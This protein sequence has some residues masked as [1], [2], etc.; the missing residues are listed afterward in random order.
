LPVDCY[1]L[2]SRDENPEMTSTIKKRI[3]TINKCAALFKQKGARK[4]RAKEKSVNDWR[5]EQQ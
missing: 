2:K 1:Y 3:N 4:I 5:Q